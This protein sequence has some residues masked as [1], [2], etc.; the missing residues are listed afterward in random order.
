MYEQSKWEWPPKCAITVGVVSCMG[1]QSGSGLLIIV[2]VVSCMGNDSGSGLQSEWEWSHIWS[3]WEW[4]AMRVGV[5]SC[6]KLV[7]RYRVVQTGGKRATC[8]PAW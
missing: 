1:N 2:E 8:T 7:W 3:K 5:V 4:L 6:G